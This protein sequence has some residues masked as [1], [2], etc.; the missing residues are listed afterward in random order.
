MKTLFKILVLAFVTLSFASCTKNKQDY[1]YKYLEITLQTDNV[2]K[3]FLSNDINKVVY[4]DSH[5]NNAG[6]N[7]PINTPQDLVLTIVN[8]SSNEAIVVVKMA[9]D[10]TKKYIIG[11][12]RSIDVMLSGVDTIKDWNNSS[13]N[14]RGD[15]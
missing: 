13:N 11:G 6:I 1:P 10:F 8:T 15:L 9:N 3:A 5:R 14:K 12:N 4:L 7:T 2:V